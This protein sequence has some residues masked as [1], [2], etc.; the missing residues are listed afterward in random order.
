MNEEIKISQFKFG[1][2]QQ[3]YE[4]KSF[5]PTLI[6]REWEI[7]NIKLQTILSQASRFLGELNAFSQLVPDID[8]FIKMHINKEAV[9][10]SK[11][12]GTQ[13]KIEEALLS[14]DD[15]IP[16][17][18]SDWIEVNN[19]I[20]AMEYSIK[21]LEALPI[22]NR[23]I[24]ETHKILL[25]GTRG[26]KKLPGEFRSSQN[27]IGGTSIKDAVFIPPHYNELPNLMS[28]LEKFINNEKINISELLRI[29]ITHYQFETIHP[30]LDGNGRI[31]RLLITLQLVSKNIL[32]KPALYLSDFF[33]KNRTLYYDNLMRVRQ[34]NDLT[35]W[36]K[37]FLVGV[38]ETSKSSVQSFKDIIALKE[39]IIS[40]RLIKLGK[41]RSRGEKLLTE[42]F[43][44]PIINA[45]QITKKINVS[46]PTAN[47]LI[48]DFQQLDILYEFTGYKR[49]RIFFF[50]EYID[51]FKES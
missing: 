29:A 31:G 33:E 4:Y 45:Q 48:K 42:L 10:S 5:L 16:E 40:E 15:L 50:H 44:D 30:F 34:T 18:R 25:E 41:R 11:I 43:K 27:W 19:Y 9:T 8:F 23:L 22:S 14:K 20:Q 7:D 49:N 26:E 46:K 35:S 36:L 38:V 17:K 12:E 39:N 51:I 37:F 47:S 28:D 3:Q 21:T 32:S 2:W 24:K 13:T 1:S 6:N